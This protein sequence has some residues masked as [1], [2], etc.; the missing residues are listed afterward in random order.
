MTEVCW[1][2]DVLLIWMCL[3]KQNY[4]KCWHYMKSNQ[5]YKYF[6]KNVKVLIVDVAKEKDIYN[7]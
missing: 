4:K 1:K 3:I 5:V 2:C 6:V 7:W